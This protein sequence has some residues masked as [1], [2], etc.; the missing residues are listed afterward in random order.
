MLLRIWNLSGGKVGLNQRSFPRKKVVMNVFVLTV[1]QY[2]RKDEVVVCADMYSAESMAQT[3]IDNRIFALKD[4][5]K[6]NPESAKDEK[7]FQEHVETLL[8]MC[9]KDFFMAIGFL[10][11]SIYNYDYDYSLPKFS[12]SLVENKVC[13]VPKP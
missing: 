8:K 5:R 10:N 6:E 2:G 9:E 4:K 11:N 7:C 1:S 3:Y 12:I 13:K